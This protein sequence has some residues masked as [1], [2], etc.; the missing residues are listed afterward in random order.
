MPQINHSRFA[1]EWRIN[2]NLAGGIVAP[3]ISTYIFYQGYITLKCIKEN[4]K[5]VN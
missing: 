4:N 5:I 3:V 2:N 1:F